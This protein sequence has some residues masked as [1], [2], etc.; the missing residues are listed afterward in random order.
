MFDEFENLWK[1]IVLVLIIDKWIIIL[2]SFWDTLSEWPDTRIGNKFCKLVQWQEFEN[3]VD[4]SSDKDIL[5]NPGEPK[6]N[7]HTGI[8]GG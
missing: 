5:H 3:N 6:C 2:T 4:R 1:F 8:D 7:I